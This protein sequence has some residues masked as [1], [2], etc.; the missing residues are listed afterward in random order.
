MP[1]NISTRNQEQERNIFCVFLLTGQP[2][3]FD[4][5][6]RDSSAILVFLWPFVSSAMVPDV[7]QQR[8]YGNWILNPWEM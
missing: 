7:F 5:L 1:P 4:L 2:E 8:K 3:I 6:R